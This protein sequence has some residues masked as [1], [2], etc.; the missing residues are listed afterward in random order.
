MD[1]TKKEERRHELVR[2][3]HYGTPQEKEAA[4]EEFKNILI[5]ELMKGKKDE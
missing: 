4:Y 5:E 3:M 1:L 2:A